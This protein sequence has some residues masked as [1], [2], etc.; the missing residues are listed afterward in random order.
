MKHFKV[1][2]STT[3]EELASVLRNWHSYNNTV[4]YQQ[5]ETIEF[6]GTPW[7]LWNNDV[8]KSGKSV[9]SV[10]MML[11]NDFHDVDV[12]QKFVYIFISK[13]SR[14]LRKFIELLAEDGYFEDFRSKVVEFINNP[15]PTVR[16]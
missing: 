16:L 14:R 6:E 10:L 12:L 4:A 7:L 1:T 13:E 11:V 5:G 9:S 2:E 3:P 8:I 15:F